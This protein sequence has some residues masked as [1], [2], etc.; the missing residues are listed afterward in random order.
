M[1]GGEGAD[2]G[3][4]TLSLEKG[5]KSTL[6]V[7]FIVHDNHRGSLS[8]IGLSVGPA[9]EKDPDFVNI[10]KAAETLKK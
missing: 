1:C 4:H 5:G 9:L 3:R 7:G 10:T 2:G 6:R 8:Q